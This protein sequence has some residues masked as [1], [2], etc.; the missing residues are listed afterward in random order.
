MTRIVRHFWGWCLVIV[1]IVGLLLP[2]MPG[3]V[4]L[5]PGLVILSDYFPWARKLVTWAREKAGYGK[6]SDRSDKRT[7][8]S[9][10]Q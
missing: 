10:N 1:G 2:V 3:W 4:F 9:G 5:I 7:D 8:A 6:H